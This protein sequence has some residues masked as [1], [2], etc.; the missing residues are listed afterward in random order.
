MKNQIFRRAVW[1]TLVLALVGIPTGVHAQADYI[2]PAPRPVPAAPQ[3]GSYYREPVSYGTKRETVPPAYVRSASKIGIAALADYSWLDIGLDSRTRY[4]YRHNDFRRAEDVDDHPFLFKS[5]AYL[6][7]RNILDPFRFAIEFQDS[8]RYN[9]DFPYDNRDI[10]E[11]E[12]IQMIGELNFKNV[13][14][15]DDLGNAR[16]I[17]FRGGRMWFEKI[18]RRLI[19]NN[20]WRNT[21]NTFQGVHLDIGQDANDWELE[22]IAT[23]PLER[24]LSDFD[25]V[26]KGQYFYSV[27]GHWRR[28]SDI[29]TIEPYYLLLYQ[30]A[31]EGRP[32]REIHAPAVRAY[33]PIGKTRFDYD[34]NIVYE[35]GHDSGRDHSAL[36]TV[37]E[38]GYSFQH[39]WKPRYSVFY[40]YADG[41]RDPDDD[42]NERF[43]RFFG[44]ARPWSAN[45]YFIWENFHAPKTRLEFIPIKELRVDA[46]MSAYW[47]ASDTDRWANANLRDPTGQSG[48]FIGY[49]FDIRARYPLWGHI[50][51]TIGYA[52]FQPGQF[53]KRLSRSDPSD[54]VYVEIT[55]NAFKK[56]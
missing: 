48:D 20:A 40:G 27:I 47:L 49:E 54:F 19:A 56:S 17:S 3:P 41:D 35:F 53:T 18:D 5:R 33:G 32:K 52:H 9:G 34:V 6:G 7:I 12:P 38:L 30:K 44:F 10:N 39:P 29:A 28:W 25:E 21:T 45:D 2:E 37:G 51:A 26:V 43:D 16:P 36:G 11:F 50:D 13:L 46:G 15:K 8:R 22:V 4:E 24:K 1:S 31:K 14:P 42:E 23:Q 55:I